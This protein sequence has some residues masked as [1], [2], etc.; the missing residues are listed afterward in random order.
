MP[1]HKAVT[2]APV[3]GVVVRPDAAA[4]VQ[5]AERVRRVERERFAEAGNRAVRPHADD[6]L[7]IVKRCLLLEKRRRDDHGVL[8]CV[9][10]QNVAV[11]RRVPAKR[12]RWHFS[13]RP[14]SSC[15]NDAL[16]CLSAFVRLRFRRWR[17]RRSCPSETRTSGNGRLP[18]CFKIQKRGGEQPI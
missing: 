11:E 6:L 3:P 16:A 15:V 4:P 12:S 1:V 13:R 9:A 17:E 10:Q 5:Q 18:A 8:R 7:V 14:P 2:R